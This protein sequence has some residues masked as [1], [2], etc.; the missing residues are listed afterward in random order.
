MDLESQCQKRNLS[1]PTYKLLEEIKG[2]PPS[3]A[4][5]YEVKVSI[6]SIKVQGSGETFKESCISGARSMLKKMR[7]M[8][9]NFD[10]FAAIDDFDSKFKEKY[11]VIK[12]IGSGGFGIVLEAKEKLTDAYVAIKRVKIPPDQNE[13]EKTLREVKVL[14]KLQHNN[15]VSFRHT[16]IEE[17]PIGNVQLYFI[18]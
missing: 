9:D 13:N 4:S 12:E 16:W 5:F 3:K 14:A 17:P 1:K 8:G 10:N 6:G 15:I 11:E 18:L 7:A 2:A